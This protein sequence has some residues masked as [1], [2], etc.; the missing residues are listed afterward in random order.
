MHPEAYSIT[1]RWFVP[2]KVRQET[3]KLSV[4]F[5]EGEDSTIDSY[6]LNFGPQHPAAHG[7]LRLLLELK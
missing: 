6:T 2:P 4:P 7:V 3:E 5:Y 1:S